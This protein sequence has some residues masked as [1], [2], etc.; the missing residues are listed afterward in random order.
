MR[1]TR[2]QHHKQILFDYSLRNQTLENVQTAK[3]LGITISNN[4]NSSKATKTLGF[5]PRNL[6]FAP[7]STKEVACKTLVRPKLEYAEPVWNPFSKLQI[8]QIEKVQRTAARWTCRRWQNINGVSKMLD[9]L[10]WPTLEARR[11]QSSLLLFHKIHCGAVSIGKK[12]KYMTPAH[13]LK[14]TSSI[15]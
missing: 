15:S 11:D 7:R 5:L 4:M 8:N 10:E 2:H 14:T 6:S 13:S 3:Y 12:N 9:G 1:V